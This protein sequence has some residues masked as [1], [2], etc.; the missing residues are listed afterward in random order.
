MWANK[1]KIHETLQNA[2]NPTLTRAGSGMPV[3]FVIGGLRQNFSFQ[4]LFAT[5]STQGM[6]PN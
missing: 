4:L 3:H 6:M 2:V 1:H 5:P